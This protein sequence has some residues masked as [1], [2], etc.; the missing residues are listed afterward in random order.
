MF[1][2]EISNKQAKEILFEELWVLCGSKANMP[3]D[4][5]IENEIEKMVKNQGYYFLGGE[6]Q[7]FCGPYI[8]KDSTKESY[9]VELPGGIELYTIVMMDGFISRSW[10]EFISFGKTGTGGWIGKDGTLCCVKSL[11]DVESDEFKV[12]FLKHEA[13][14]AFDKK[15]YP[16][17]TTL[18][19]EYRA[20]LVEL[21]Y[22]NNDKTIK[23][24]L[25]EADNSNPE[26]S[27]SMAAYEIINEMSREVFAC[28]YMIDEKAWEDNVEKIRTTA[29]QM[30]K[31]SNKR[32]D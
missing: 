27:H 26:N 17:I 6:T 22:S 1:W 8:W 3:K 9:E 18:Q 11:Y 25:K 14:H 23:K 12:S 2:K 21:I 31:E 30:F 28:E 7:G 15:K 16:D 10:L 24:F 32:L 29:F 20:K 13:Q 5:A 19:L 4:S